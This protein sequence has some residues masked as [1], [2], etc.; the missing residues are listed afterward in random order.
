[1]NIEVNFFII[2]E[3]LDFKSKQIKDSLIKITNQIF[4]NNFNEN[5]YFKFY[6]TKKIKSVEYTSQTE[7]V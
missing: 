4:I 7:K 1:M 6:L 3:N 2:E 5:N